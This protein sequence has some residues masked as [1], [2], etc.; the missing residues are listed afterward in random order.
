M[1]LIV[2]QS[3]TDHDA[4]SEYR[5]SFSCM[6]SVITTVLSSVTKGKVMPD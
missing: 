6:C 5:F 3:D 4:E 1:K 2:V